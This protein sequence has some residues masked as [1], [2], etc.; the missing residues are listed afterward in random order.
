M[1]RILA[2]LLAVWIFSPAHAQDTDAWFA[3][4]GE[5][6]TPVANH[7]IPVE[8]ESQIETLPGT[9]VVGNPR[10][11]VTLVEFY[12][13]NCPYCRKAAGDIADLVA[14]DQELKLI[15]VPFPVL[16]I[17]SI[18]A[19]RVELAV[20]KLAP[21]RFY[22]FHRKIYAGRGVVDGNRALAVAQ[23]IGLTADR[24][25]AAANDDSVTEMMKSHVRLGDAMGLAATPSFV[26]K[27]V[28]IVGYP[29]RDSLA[30]IVRAIRSCDKV[31]C[32]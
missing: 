15:L 4:K 28:A 30:G 13:L 22:E 29:G 27:G 19:G 8:L 9:V 21:A 18:A 25:I 26:V 7:R 1:I 11:D 3:I 10:G 31:V 6:G 17:P 12:D 24:A 2:L 32:G 16:G 23:E 5:D 14:A 20:A